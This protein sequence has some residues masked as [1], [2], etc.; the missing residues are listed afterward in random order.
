MR[1]KGYRSIFFIR[2][3]KLW[4]MGSGA[5]QLKEADI[6]FLITKKDHSHDDY[7]LFKT[8]SLKNY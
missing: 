8:F 1:N 6:D 5:V 3:I 4:Q 7:D 2:P